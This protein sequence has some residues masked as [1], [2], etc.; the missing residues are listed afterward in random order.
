MITLYDNP[1]SPFARK[2]RLVLD[3][4]RLEYDVVDGLARKNRELLETVNG[5]VEVPA[6]V[7]DG[8]VVVNSSDIV[9]YLERVF[10]ERSVYPSS[11]AG[12]ARAR[13]W[14]RCS[15]T[16]V[17][18]ILIDI[19]YWVWAER[20][21]TMPEGLLD[22]ARA[23]IGQVYAA[24][25]RELAGREFVC[26]ELSIA[27]FAL[28]PQLTG[29]KMLDVPIDGSRFP[30]LLGWYKRMRGL[31]VCQADLDR[32]K[33]YLAR[34]PAGLDVER[35]KIFWRGD[36]LEWILAKGHHRWLM[37]EIEEGR[38]IWPGLAIPKSVEA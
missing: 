33:T 17:D 28:F 23:D 37:R 9:A 38:V 24:L 26:E 19:S 20:A 11:P 12:W 15:D 30:A 6:L 34:G 1:F 2:V 8:I 10:P 31:D 7:H 4:K 5:R 22:A 21:D 35:H 14:E 13:A 36:R 18:A 32:V 3:H 29:A 27:D 16:T 25:E